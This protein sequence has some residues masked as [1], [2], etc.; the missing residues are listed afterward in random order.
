MAISNTNNTLQFTWMDNT[1]TTYNS[2]IPVPFT[3]DFAN[4][5][6][7]M[8]TLIKPA[9]DLGLQIGGSGFRVSQGH[10]NIVYTTSGTVSVS[11]R[12]KKKDIVEI[13][14]ALDIVM[15][16]K[17]VSYKFIEGTSGRTHTGFIAQDCQNLVCDNWAGYVKNENDYGLRYEE[18][19]ALNSKAIQELN[20][21]VKKLEKRKAGSIDIAPLTEDRDPNR[22][23]P[24][25]VRDLVQIFERL[26]N[27]EN[28]PL[29]KSPQPQLH[30]CIE[31]SRINELNDR[32]SALECNEVKGSP[33]SE[34]FEL[35]H[36]LMEKNHQLELKVDELERKLNSIPKVESKNEI[37]ESD[38]GVNMMELLQQK[39]FEL[40]QRLIKMEKQNKKLVQAVNKLLRTT[41]VE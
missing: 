34:E 33:S 31:I 28:Q 29:S 23:R 26:D 10:F 37:L 17:P 20:E 41:T 5:H 32:I 7:I 21:K 12:N 8:N 1:G 3:L 24:T 38:G 15:K 40:E 39:N 25:V 27:L 9:T 14:S 36:S 22:L 16:L 30:R 4:G 2:G 19:I 35:V 6:T 18:F 11:D 13:Q